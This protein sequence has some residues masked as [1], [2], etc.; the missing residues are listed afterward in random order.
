MESQHRTGG[1]GN[2]FQRGV[3]LLSDTSVDNAKPVS[4]FDGS[5]HGQ[6]GTKR[7]WPS[8]TNPLDKTNSTDGAKIDALEILEKFKLKH[9]TPLA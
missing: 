1:K 9:E 3:L 5:G 8:G 4:L 6:S 7:Y 2:D